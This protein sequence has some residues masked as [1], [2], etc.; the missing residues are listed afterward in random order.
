MKFIDE[1]R[2]EVFAGRGGNGVASFRREKFVPFGGPDGGD[3]GKGGSVYAVAD[4]NV[5]TLVEFRFVKKYLAEH[6]ER[7]RGADCYGKGGDDIEL[8]MPVGTVITDHD[9]GELVADLTHHGQR[10]M[11]ARGGKGGLGN[12]HFKS[13]TNRAPRQCTPGEQGEQRTLKLELK[14]LADVGLLGMPNAGKSTFIR[15]VSAARPKVADYPFTTLHPNLGVVR[16]DDTRSFVIA[17]IPGLIE[18]AAEGAGL[19]HRFLKHL[20][21]T[22]LLLHVV[23]VAPFDP[24]VDPVRE[25]RAIVEELKKYDE[26]L[27]GKPRWLVL[28]KV[29]MLPPDERELTVSAFLKAYGWPEE[30]PDDRFGFDIKAPRVFSIS[31]LN[32]EGTRELTF[33]IMSYLD[34][35]RA[36]QRKL[37][38]EAQQ[39]A[40]AARQTVIT[41]DAAMHQDTTEE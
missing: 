17:D 22:G 29:D 37:A 4:E 36:E 9:T 25:A 23:D 8:K 27:H 3:G 15:A 7:G 30:Q 39:Q 21:R 18:G 35:V 33:A 34:V 28:N 11:I 14:V 2:I 5:N 13:S 26:E 32:H 41:P 19:G 24:D 38:D 1:A 12:I 40:A 16:M 6:G 31:A 20:Q 10:I